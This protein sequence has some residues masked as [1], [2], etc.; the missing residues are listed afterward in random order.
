M[1]LN[2]CTSASIYS[3]QNQYLCDAVV[4]D[5]QENSVLL[6]M[7]D[8]TSDFLSSE[9]HVTFYDNVMGLV[10]YVCNFTDYSEYYPEQGV[11]KS[12]V[13]CSI[14]EQIAVLQRR[15][16][17]KVPVNI[18]VEVTLLSKSQTR[19]STPG[20]IRNISAGGVFLTC[21]HVFHPGDFV[22]FSLIL[23]EGAAPVPLNVHILRVQDRDLLRRMIG[24]DAN[25]ETLFGYGC[26]FVDMHSRT[27]SLVRNFVF[28]QDL[29]HRKTS[30]YE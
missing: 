9:S 14:G 13:R 11:L 2:N 17:L 10:T 15:H 1:R 3:L 27:E 7:E 16:D 25:D 18:H 19:V 8:S 24:R 28:R 22:T 30:T 26:R 5:I 29:L 4:S 6:T 21:R 12:A 20:M 23:K